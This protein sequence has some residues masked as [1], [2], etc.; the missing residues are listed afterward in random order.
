MFEYVQ[1]FIFPEMYFSSRF[2]V[3][4]AVTNITSIRAGLGK[5]VN[6][7]GLKKN[8]CNWKNFQF[9]IMKYYLDKKENYLHL[10]KKP[11][12][13]SSCIFFNKMIVLLAEGLSIPF[14]FQ[15]FKLFLLIKACLQNLASIFCVFF[16]KLVIFSLLSRH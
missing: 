9:L 7:I 6:N 16:L 12:A 11:N 5:L 2:Q 4:L 3:V 15:N 13:R 14:K 10:S 1:I 8:L